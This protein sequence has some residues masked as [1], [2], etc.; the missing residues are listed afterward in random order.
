M[1][2][3]LQEAPPLHGGAPQPTETRTILP[4][5]KD[6]DEFFTELIDTNVHESYRVGLK[7]QEYC[8]KH[9]LPPE[10]RVVLRDR[11]IDSL[12]VLFESSLSR[13][14]FESWFEP[15]KAPARHT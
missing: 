3:F 8:V 6:W 13:T 11:V 1:N 5:E 15:R 12:V 10:G 14:F 9:N 4:H 2:A 7:F